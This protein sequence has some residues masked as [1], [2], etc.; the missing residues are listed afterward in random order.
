MQA[1][2]YLVTKSNNTR[3]LGLI[4]E[5]KATHQAWRVL[6]SILSKYLYSLRLFFG[7]TF[8]FLEKKGG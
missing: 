4:R 5:L 2:K 1:H 7:P 8:L 6:C 3:L